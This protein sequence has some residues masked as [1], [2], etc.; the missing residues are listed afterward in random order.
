MSHIS[1]F[2]PASF[3]EVMMKLKPLEN[4]SGGDDGGGDD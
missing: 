1:L 3:Y 4:D 2:N